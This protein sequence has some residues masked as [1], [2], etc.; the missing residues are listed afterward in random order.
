MVLCGFQHDL[1]HTTHTAH[2][3]SCTLHACTVSWKRADAKA[4]PGLRQRARWSPGRYRWI[5][6]GPE[7][8]M[9]AGVQVESW[10][11]VVDGQG[12]KLLA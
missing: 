12:L 5:A 9:S 8:L 4:E 3:T 6:Q 10:A 1:L 2:N 11:L 7:L